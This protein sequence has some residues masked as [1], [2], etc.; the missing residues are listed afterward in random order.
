MGQRK[1]RKEKKR[2]K[3]KRLLIDIDIFQT[4]YNRLQII[5]VKQLALISA[6]M[7]HIILF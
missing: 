3:T 4:G 2:I 5:I 1:Q 7:K 6:T